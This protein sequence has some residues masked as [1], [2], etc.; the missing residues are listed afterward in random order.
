ML[1]AGTFII[2]KQLN[3][4]RSKELGYNKDHVLSFPM[5]AMH[6]HYDAVKAELLRTPGVL[7]VTRGSQNIIDLAGQSGDNYWDGKQPGQTG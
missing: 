4:I 6:D 3:F 5:R 1:I 7:E 2:S